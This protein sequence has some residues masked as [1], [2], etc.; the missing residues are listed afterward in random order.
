MF[1]SSFGCCN[2]NIIFQAVFGQ[3]CCFFILSLLPIHFDFT[4]LW[5]FLSGVATADH[6]PSSNPNPNYLY[7]LFYKIQSSPPLKSSSSPLI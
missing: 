4:L 3:I 6:L 2:V 1:G 7:V 5:L